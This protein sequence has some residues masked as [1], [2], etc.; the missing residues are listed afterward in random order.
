MRMEVMPQGTLDWMTVAVATVGEEAGIE[1][2]L[3]QEGPGFHNSGRTGC[4]GAEVTRTCGKMRL[5]SGG[6]KAGGMI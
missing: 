3:P 5:P 4:Q 1:G 2:K 6:V